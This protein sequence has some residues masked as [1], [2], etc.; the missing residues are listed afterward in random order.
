LGYNGGVDSLHHLA[1]IAAL[2]LLGGLIIGAAAALLWLFEGRV[3]GISGIAGGLIY[4]PPKD[5]G[6]RWSFVLGLLV[7]GALMSLVLP[8]AFASSPVSLGLSAAAGLLV[9]IGTTLGNGCTSGHGVCGISRMSK[10]SLAATACFIG[11][12]MVTALVTAR[13]LGVS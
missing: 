2:P 8:S 13:V 4:A 10:R 7:G 11:A 5:R 6:W 9:G 3:A 12:G 1:S